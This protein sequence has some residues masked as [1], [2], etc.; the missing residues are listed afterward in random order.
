MMRREAPDAFGTAFLDI[1][2]CGFGAIVL[3]ILIFKFE[4]DVSGL[5]SV[6]NDDANA[7]IK[8]LYGLVDELKAE[9]AID[10]EQSAKAKAAMLKT[11]QAKLERAMAETAKLQQTSSELKKQLGALQ[12][13]IKKQQIAGTSEGD[14]SRQDDEVGGIPV[15]RDYVIFIVDTS[16]SMKEI[17]HKVM[18]EIDNILTVHPQLKGFQV[19]NDNGNYL[20]SGYA[21]KWMKD[22]PS[23]RKRAM[24]L[25]SSW[26]SI[27]NSSPVEGIET[28]LTRYSK[29]TKDLSI[30]VIGDD[31]TGTNFDQVILRTRQLNKG[32]ARI[33]ALNF[34]S[35]NAST[36]RFSTLMREICRENQGTFLTF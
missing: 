33:H 19:I 31:F 18:R 30:Y 20:V 35:P 15:D 1:I 22:T 16:G 10:N 26:A 2:S 5:A 34:I 4:P 32:R 9:P 13:Q 24:K 28:A 23:M 7:K 3:L 6:K 25:F 14:Q 36:D 21:G 11:A 29:Y 17:W 12:K 27:S 8:Q